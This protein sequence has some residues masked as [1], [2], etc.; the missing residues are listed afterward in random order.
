MNDMPIWWGIAVDKSSFVSFYR[1]K[2]GFD[3]KGG[4]GGVKGS[5]QD[6]R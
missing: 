2:Y 4:A 6:F 5:N 3:G 1:K